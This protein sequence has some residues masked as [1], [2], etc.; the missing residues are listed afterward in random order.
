MVQHVSAKGQAWEPLLDTK[1]QFSS[2][3]IQNTYL[4]S[5]CH[6]FLLTCVLSV[7]LPSCVPALLPGLISPLNLSRTS[8]VSAALFPA[9]LHLRLH[10]SL[11]Q[12]VSQPV[13][14]S[15]SLSARLLSFASPVLLY[16]FPCPCLLPVF[17]ICSPWLSGP[18][19][20]CITFVLFPLP[21][22]FCCHFLSAAIFWTSAD[23]S[24][25]FVLPPAC[26][27]LV[28]GF[29]LCY[30]DSLWVNA[31][32]PPCSDSVGECSSVERK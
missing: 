25:L 1:W 22:F 7:L 29:F 3:Y 19:H 32:L 2:E 13:L 11:V 5:W 14:I 26:L 27:C 9:S 18:I 16:L 8:L 17:Q 15:H 30:C 21:A 6:Y 28:L 4:L 20:F 10:P 12:F 23:E 24:S 31:G